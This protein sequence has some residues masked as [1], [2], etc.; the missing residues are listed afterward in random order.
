MYLFSLIPKFEINE[1]SVETN[2]YRQ[3][4]HVANRFFDGNVI[5]FHTEAQIYNYENI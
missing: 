5:S 2:G 3:F 4:G 1:Y